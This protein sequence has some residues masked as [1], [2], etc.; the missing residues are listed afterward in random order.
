MTTQGST[1]VPP[2][3]G[4][5]LRFVLAVVLIVVGSVPSVILASWLH[6][7]A[8]DIQV[9]DVSQRSL[10]L[11]KTLARFIAGDL[12][13]FRHTLD[14]IPPVCAAPGADRQR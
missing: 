1:T 14:A 2:R 9:D 5:R 3:Q 13:E 8:I 4:V 12:N 6:A 7:R 10:L 11:A